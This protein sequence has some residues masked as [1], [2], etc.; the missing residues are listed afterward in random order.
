MPGCQFGAQ[1][2]GARNS[3]SSRKKNGVT[4][5]CPR[6]PTSLNLFFSVCFKPF[7][8]FPFVLELVFSLFRLRLPSPLF[9]VNKQTVC[10]Y[11]HYV[12]K[13]GAS[14]LENTQKKKKQPTSKKTTAA[15]ACKSAVVHVLGNRSIPPEY[16]GQCCNFLV[17]RAPR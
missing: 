17:N 14:F 3:V 7:P 15:F 11:V 5:I 13:D 16:S 10:V 12:I 4:S 8:H 1:N 2:G 6:F 9:N